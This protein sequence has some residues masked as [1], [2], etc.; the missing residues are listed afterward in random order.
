MGV[1]KK[2]ARV[3]RVLLSTE[4]RKKLHQT[5]EQSKIIDIVE[6]ALHELDRKSI[7]VPANFPVDYADSLRNKG[8]SIHV[9]PE[10]FFETRVKKTPE[11]I[12]WIA[13]VQAAGEIAMEEAIKVIK[14]SK[15]SGGKLYF[16]GEVLTSEKLKTIIHH[17]L[18]DLGCTAQG[19]IVACGPQTCDPHDHGHGP[20]KANKPIIIDIFPRSMKTRYWADMTRT[21]V[22]GK[23]PKKIKE[24]YD[25]VLEAQQL[26]INA[27]SDNAES[28]DVHLAVKT[29][30]EMRGFKTGLIDGKMQ[31]FIHGTG[32]G[33]GIDIHELPVI[34]N[35]PVILHKGN[36]ISVEPGL[37][38][39]K[40]GGVRL[41]DLVVV[42]ET[43]RKNLTKFPKELEIG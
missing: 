38:Y 3:D 14:K 13:Q 35:T 43:G 21:V 20:L 18:L 30:F 10:P 15:V 40:I 29:V 4:Y 31:G 12:R 9:K 5:E 6:L 32:H 39:D 37:Y 36:V 26:G 33:V 41:E 23:A 24:L 8:F 34:R 2:T 28:N 7:Y 11:E 42:T 27:V 25:A 1:L 16:K 22:K 17:I 19:T